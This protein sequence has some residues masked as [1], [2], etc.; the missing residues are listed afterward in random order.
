MMKKATLY[1]AGAAV[2][3][4]TALAATQPATAALIDATGSISLAP[5]GASTVTPGPDITADTDTKTDPG[6]TV[7]T[8]NGNFTTGVSV[9]DAGTFGGQPIEI[10]QPPGGANVDISDFTLAI[11][12][13]TFTFTTGSTASIIATDPGAG[14][15]GFINSE[16]Q[17]TITDGGGIFNTGTAVNLSETCTQATIGGAAGDITCTNGLISTAAA[18]PEPASLAILG[19]SL[20]GFGVLRRRKA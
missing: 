5:T 1:A 15:A 13:I 17:G 6:Q 18:V 9:G 11:N 12:G 7:V 19:M 3:A 2:A 14:T 20:L 10:P 8:V 4:L 16:Y